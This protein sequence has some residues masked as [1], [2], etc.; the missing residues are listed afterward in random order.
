MLFSFG[1]EGEVAP[2]PRWLALGFRASFDVR[3]ISGGLVA[4]SHGAVR[5]FEFSVKT[6]PVD[7]GHGNALA[8]MLKTAIDNRRLDGFHADDVGFAGGVMVSL[9]PGPVRLLAAAG[10]GRQFPV[11][12][13]LSA[14]N[15][16]QWIFQPSIAVYGPHNIGFSMSGALPFQESMWVHLVDMAVGYLHAGD[17][18]KGALMFL[19]PITHRSERADF[20]LLLKAGWEF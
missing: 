11:K 2:V 18:F 16:V 10:I 7:D 13:G 17:G 3:T 1:L 4:D 9:A 8:L 6:T 12:E 14:V 15:L 5:A 19:F 20:G